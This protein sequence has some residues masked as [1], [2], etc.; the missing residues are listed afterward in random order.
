MTSSESS[1]II[2]TVPQRTA[3]QT[4]RKGGD[5]V[6]INVH[7][8]NHIHIDGTSKPDKDE[9]DSKTDKIL[10]LVIRIIELATVLIT[11][12]YIIVEKTT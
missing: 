9:T 6:R 5:S 8:H 3:V 4:V 11:V 7:I 12:G 10:T 1:A 2:L